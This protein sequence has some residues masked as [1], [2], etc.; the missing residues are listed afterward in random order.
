MLLSVPASSVYGVFTPMLQKPEG[1]K[2][3]IK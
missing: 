1:I 2:D 3:G